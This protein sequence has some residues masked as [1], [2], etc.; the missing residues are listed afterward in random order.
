MTRR[1]LI[2]IAILLL[3]A[4]ALPLLVSDYRVFQF[5]LCWC[6]RSRCSA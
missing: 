4:C 3:V 6:M 5:N 1:Q 2:P